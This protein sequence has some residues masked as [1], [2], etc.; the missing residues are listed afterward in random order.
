MARNQRRQRH[1]ENKSM[2][3]QLMTYFLVD[4]QKVTWLTPHA[5]QQVM[6]QD[7]DYK[8][9]LTILVFYEFVDQILFLV[10]SISNFE[11]INLKYPHIIDPR[12]K[13]LAAD[14]YALTRYVGAK[15]RT[16]GTNDEESELRLAQLHDQLPSNEP[17]ALMN[18][19]VNAIFVSENDEET[20]VS[21]ESLLF[22]ITSFGGVVSW[23]EGATFKES[24]YYVADL[25]SIRRSTVVGALS[26]LSGRVHA[27]HHIL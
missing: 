9:M 4:D 23:G 10:L 25:C 14:L 21:R 15:D 18:L 22:V 27:V 26:I 6:P 3:Y 20:R 1:E 8:I 2:R 13:A 7:V 16:N 19:V 5:L 24:L 12:L 17:G 11:L